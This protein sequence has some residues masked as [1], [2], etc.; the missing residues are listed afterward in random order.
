MKRVWKAYEKRNYN[1]ILL[2]LCTK[3]KH[4]YYIFTSK[5]P[6]GTHRCLVTIKKLTLLI[7][8]LKPQIVFSFNPANLS[9][10]DINLFHSDHKVAAL[11]SY[12]S[13]FT[14]KNEFIYPRKNGLH[15]VDK[16]IYFWSDKP[17]YFVNIT[18]DINF[19]L[20]VLSSY[21]SQFPNFKNF[22]EYFKRNFSVNTKKFKYS[23]A[24]RVINDI[25]LSFFKK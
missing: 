18:E 24:F 4:Y 21:K 3:K 8:V 9:F 2:L 25:E 1:E 16:M 11:V 12:D 22:S 14:A 6:W 7:K 5:V 10:S 15:K 23:E 17:N 20:D 19:K 13:I